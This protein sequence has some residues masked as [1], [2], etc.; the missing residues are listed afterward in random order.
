MLEG[1]GHEVAHGAGGTSRSTPRLPR[2]L[3]EGGLFG[4]DKGAHTGART[5]H[6]ET[7][8]V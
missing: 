5:G 3:V 8:R 1:A 4:R 2:D 6:A 7:A